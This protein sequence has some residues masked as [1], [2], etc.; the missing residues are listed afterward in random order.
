M[1]NF[2]ALDTAAEL[3][4][5]VMGLWSAY[6]EALPLTV[7]PVRYEDLIAEPEAVLRRLAGT[8]GVEFEPAMLDH[9]A[10]AAARGR[11]AT[12]SYS[13][14]ARPLHAEAEGRW[15]RYREPM[16]PVLDILAPWAARWGYDL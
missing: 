8:L 3:Y 7:E 2:L 6:A 11:I 1:A 5:G 4:D 16:A 13:Q 9:Q 15:R 10:T 14:V 12:P